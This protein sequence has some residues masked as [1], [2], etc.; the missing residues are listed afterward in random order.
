MAAETIAG[1]A[2]PDSQMA[3]E[4]TTFICDTETPLLYHHS[5]RTYLFG[6]LHGALRGQSQIQNC[7]MSPRC[8]T[9]SASSKATKTFVSDS[10]SMAL[11]PHGNS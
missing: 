7:Y 11:T 8:S 4:T 2:I 5:R 1:I 3:Q 10:R 6:M 9:T